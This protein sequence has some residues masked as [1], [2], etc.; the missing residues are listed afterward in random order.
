MKGRQILIEPRP[1]GGDAAALMLDGRLED[2]LVDPDPADPAPRPEAIYRAV[3]G[4]PMKGL[5]GVI[6]DLGGGLSGFLRGPKLPAP[7]RPLL[8]QVS[9]WAEPGKAP[10]VTARVLL[11]GRL[12]ILTPGAPGIN[13]ARSLHDPERRSRLTALP[14]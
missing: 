2:L 6:V 4:R 14:A 10:P 5:G 13:V 7:G 9:G 3:P 11:K 8:V 1:A 12:A